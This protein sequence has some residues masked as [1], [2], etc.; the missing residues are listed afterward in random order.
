MI[1]YLLLV[2]LLVAFAGC[3]EEFSLE[4]DFQDIP[5]VY[6]YLE[7]A[8]DTQY[9]RVERGIQGGGGDAGAVARDPRRLYYGEDA[10][11][12]SLRNLATNEEV[13][14]TRVDA[15]REGLRRDD[16][17][18]A[19]E[20]N[21][22][23]RTTRQEIDLRGGQDVSITVS[24]EGQTDARAETTM[25]QP[26]EI[27]RPTTTVRLD[28]YRRPQLLSWE[29]SAEAVVFAVAF[30][31]DIREFD[32]VD[33]AKDRTVSITYRADER[34]RPS[35]ENRSGNSVRY[36]LD[37][38]ALYRFIGQALPVTVGTAR[39][40]DALSLRV[41]GVGE[42]VARLLTLEGANAGLTSSQSLP[43]YTNVEG[44]QGVVTSRSSDV[45]SGIQLDEGSLDSL[46]EGR[47]T[48]ALNFR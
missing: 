12:V 18:F 48:K 28:D 2:P 3:R 34:Y 43:R 27:V 10:A 31:F 36:E 11:R 5:V 8:A 19:G 39:R 29:A 35:G 46:G 13:V 26:I 40:L 24:R 32:T 25:L 38:E 16:G 1:K 17:V 47:Y 15:T 30:T 14:L 6:A 9:V 20:P 41:T 4:A 23:Y 45:R 7:A 33:P 44:G 42:E 22:L 37:N 21:I